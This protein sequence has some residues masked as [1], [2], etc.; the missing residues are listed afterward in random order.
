MI[1]DKVRTTVALSADLL[2]AVDAAVQEGEAGSRNE[3]LDRALRNQ[4]AADRRSRIDAQFAQ[5]AS[6]PTYQREAQALAE[7]SAAASWE[8]LRLAEGEP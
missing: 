1:S 6:D 5:M 3:F 7:E 4:L 8:A 2:H